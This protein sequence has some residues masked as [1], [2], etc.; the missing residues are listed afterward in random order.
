MR[1]RLNRRHLLGDLER[2]DSFTLQRTDATF[3]GE[4]ADETRAGP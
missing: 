1:L 2:P 4:D 3:W